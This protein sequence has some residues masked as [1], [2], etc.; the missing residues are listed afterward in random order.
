MTHEQQVEEF[1]QQLLTNLADAD[2]DNDELVDLADDMSEMADA[3][4]RTFED[5]G[6]LT[7]NKGVVLRLKNGSEFQIAVHQSR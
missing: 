5:M 3:S 7:S 6:L 4:V 2:P 1:L